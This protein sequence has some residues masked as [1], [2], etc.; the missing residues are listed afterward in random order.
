M[1]SPP[2]PDSVCTGAALASNTRTVVSSS[3]CNFKSVG[4]NETPRTGSACALTDFRLFRLVCQYLM[5]PVSSPVSS[6]FSFLLQHAAWMRRAPAGS[7][8]S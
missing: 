7:S 3:N 6:Q 1:T 4:A 5:R 8:Q 2:C